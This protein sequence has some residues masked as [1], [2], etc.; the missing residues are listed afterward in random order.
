MEYSIKKFIN[1][2]HI[3]MDI[4]LSFEKKEV[5]I[6]IK[7]VEDQSLRLNRLRKAVLNGPTWTEEEYQQYLNFKN[8]NQS[9]D[10]LHKWNS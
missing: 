2:T 7:E 10:P 1:S 6:S 4:P 5:I 8:N 9:H 3:E